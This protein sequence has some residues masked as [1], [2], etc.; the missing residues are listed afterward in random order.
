M[1]SLLLALGTMALSAP[2]QVVP[3]EASG[4]FV[5]DLETATAKKADRLQIARF[6]RC[7]VARDGTGAKKMLL[8]QWSSERIDLVLE[9]SELPNWITGR[10]RGHGTC[11]LPEGNF[12]PDLFS[13]AVADALIRKSG[14]RLGAGRPFKTSARE[15]SHTD[16]ARR[17]D[18]SEFNVA[19]NEAAADRGDDASGARRVRRAVR[20][21]VG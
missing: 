14:P 9:T 21:W 4:V 18:Y 6:A 11:F 5:K 10:G 13:Y 8:E 17:C 12:T 19:G 1:I 7:Y 20:S 2:P 16:D 3:P 15:G